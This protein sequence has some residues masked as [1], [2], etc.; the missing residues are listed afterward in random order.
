M[1]G[2]Q[3]LGGRSRVFNV[4]PAFGTKFL[5]FCQDPAARRRALILDK[6]VTDWL[7]GHAGIDLN[8]LPWSP[9]TYETYLDQMHDWAARLEV[10]PQ[11]V[12]LVMFR[13][14][15]GPDSPWR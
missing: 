10:E 3:E 7:R 13:E 15:V 2:Y 6:N 12:E 1:A 4:G 9:K 14:A 11:V 8:P 5:F